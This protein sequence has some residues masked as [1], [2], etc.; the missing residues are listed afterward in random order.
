[1]I[2]LHNKAG[3]QNL[4]NLFGHFSL[5]LIISVLSST[6][7]A[8]SFSEFKKSQTDLFNNYK[9]EHDKTFN[10]Y[11]K[12]NWEGYSSKKPLSFYEA[13]KPVSILPTIE[14]R[15]KRLGPKVQMKTDVDKKEKS[16]AK[17]I[18][19]VIVDK[20]SIE[21][22]DMYINFFGTKLG[23]DIPEGI[24]VSKFYPQNQKGIENFFNNTA[25][26]EYEPFIA[27]INSTIKELN[28]NDWGKYLLVKKISEKI[29][30][31]VD[32]S[33]L[34][35]WFIFNKLGYSVRV[36]LANK[37]VIVMFNS[38]KPIY[39]TPHYSIGKKM[40]YA[41]SEYAKP[42]VGKVY[43]YNHDYPD[44]SSSFDLSMKTLPKLSKNIKSKTL[45]FK[46]YSKKYDI[47]YTYNQN[48]I[49]FMSTYPQADYET[50]F[51]TPLS[52]QS[53]KDIVKGL[54]KH[55]NGKETSVAINFVLSF[56][57]K[58]F[59]YEPD[60]KQ[61]GREKV[62]FAQET[63]F[64]NKSDCEDRAI[65][66]SYLVKELFKISVVGVKYKDHMATALYI[67]MRGDSVR[68]NSRKFIIADPTYIN[69][70]VGE[71]MNKYKNIKPNS[72]IFLTDS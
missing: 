5:L 1:M 20:Q 11:L 31:G 8:E 66:F 19:I 59:K 37:H 22:R 71:S 29:F 64:Y 33:R 15:V 49:D 47:D 10:K 52:A 70:N 67:P 3:E 40:F 28:L 26:V 42:S 58:S 56:V 4:Y 72:F 12:S 60:N 44:S 51:N 27:S 69:S 65:L 57:Q 45:S 50:F 13:P 32:D 53:Y 38:D 54:R 7:S 61:F 43:T 9:N 34:L 36:G 17:T 2:N 21:P 63:L 24:V 18:A 35:S 48:L 23:F 55:I 62:M 14:K 16:E 41:V 30:E 46:Q 25:L 68:V 39:A 6:I